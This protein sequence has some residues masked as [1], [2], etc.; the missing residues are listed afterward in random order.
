MSPTA[1]TAAASKASTPAGAKTT[2]KTTTTTAAPAGPTS[3]HV[4]L[5][6]SGSMA[7]IRAATIEG[8]NAYL[9]EQAAIPGARFSLTQF[10][11]ES[12]DQ[13][14]LDA[15]IEQV[16]PL[17]EATFVPRGSTPLYDAVGRAIGAL[18]AAAPLGRVVMVIITDGEENASREWTRQAVL[19]RVSDRRAAGWEF[20]FLGAGV[21]A[22]RMGTGL[23]VAASS[24]MR[25]AAE[26]AAAARA[27]SA[28][29]SSLR[30]YR[31]G[32]VAAVEM[33]PELPDEAGDLGP[34]RQPGRR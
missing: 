25:Y 11:S 3:I 15:P 1:K 8:Y 30:A 4:V 20:V 32:A 14:Y 33:P 13:L 26:P 31:S 17:S 24:T 18:E 10:D 21:D 16:A 9:A 5:D 12:I 7:A 19:E 29:S 22:Y 27:F 6:R 34:F 23:G 28:V 2:S